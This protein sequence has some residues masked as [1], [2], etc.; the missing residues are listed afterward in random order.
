MV[1]A[2]PAGIDSITSAEPS[3][4]WPAGFS[5]RPPPDVVMA[6]FGTAYASVIDG[7][8]LNTRDVALPARPSCW[9]TCP[10]T[11]GAALMV[12]PAA[13]SDR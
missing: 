10:A 7:P 4:N 11:V 12:M 3:R 2:T 6:L 9:T 1:S 5:R 13:E 8:G